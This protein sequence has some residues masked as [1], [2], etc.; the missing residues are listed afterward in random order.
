MGVEGERHSDW[1]AT[2]MLWLVSGKTGFYPFFSLTMTTGGLDVYSH[3]S[4]REAA[5]A[6]RSARLS[7]SRRCR[8]SAKASFLRVKP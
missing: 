6:R 4:L 1:G 7:K 8:H 2:I 5:L 3:E